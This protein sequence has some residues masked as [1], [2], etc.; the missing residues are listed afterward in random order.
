M[1]PGIVWSVL[2]VH[3]KGKFAAEEKT[4]G[5][6]AK[7]YLEFF[8]GIQRVAELDLV[9]TILPTSQRVKLLAYFYVLVWI[10]KM[11]EVE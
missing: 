3:K 1:A 8:L 6:R 5:Q 10:L 11:M 2:F 4:T 7:V 9:R